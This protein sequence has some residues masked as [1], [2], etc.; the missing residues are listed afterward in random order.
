MKKSRVLV[1]L[2]LCALSGIMFTNILYA[3]SSRL[4]NL[5][6]INF[7]ERNDV[8]LIIFDLSKQRIFKA[9]PYSLSIPM[10][11]D[12]ELG[13]ADYPF[14]QGRMVWSLEHPDSPLQKDVPSWMRTNSFKAWMWGRVLLAADSVNDTTTINK[15]LA[16]LRILLDDTQPTAT[17]NPAFYT[18]AWAYRAAYNQQEYAISKDK[19]LQG[20][21][22][23]DNLSDALW[24]WVMN[25]QAAAYAHDLA[26]YETCKQQIISVAHTA[27]V[28]QALTKGLLRTAASNDYPAWAMA[29][30]RYAARVVGDEALYAELESSLNA[31]IRE[32]KKAGADAEYALAVIENQLAI[33]SQ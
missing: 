9:T 23:L 22:K 31:S 25:L 27:T 30:V 12:A 6:D 19:M 29:K 17:D 16:N 8:F 18:W 14:T 15:A 3:D 7:T 33:H 1:I 5:K 4:K 24:A 26:T 32:A 21:Y 28:S 11:G 10:I 13:T 20:A 2:L